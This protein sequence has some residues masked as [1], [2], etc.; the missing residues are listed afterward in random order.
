MTTALDRAEPRNM[1]AADR[2]ASGAASAR[3]KAI[4]LMLGAI[5]SFSFLDA[6]AKVMTG[7]LDTLQIVWARYLTHLLFALVL[8]NPF[9]S[10]G[11]FKSR[12]WTLEIV[13]AVLLLG[14][15]ACNFVALR[16]LQLDETTSIIFATP[17]LVAVLAG[18]LLGEWIGPRR[19]AAI[20]VGFIGV[21]IVLKPGFGG[22]HWAAFFSVLSMICYAFYSITTRKLAGVDSAGTMLVISALVALVALTPVVPF[23]WRTPDGLLSWVLLGLTG[24]FGGFG[25]WLL[26]LAHRLAPASILMPFTYSQIVWMVLLGYLVF[27]DVPTGS[28][29]LGAGVVIASGL[30]LLHRERIRAQRL[31]RA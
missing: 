11:L 7:Q 24:V 8:F 26:I 29:L 4:G 12:N 22:L 16:Y 23:V 13:R 6:S 21:L 27:N 14:S 25:H 19:W 30:Y 17:L 9:T 28:T 2:A 15:T 3:L 31:K 5:L 18:P 1:L 20:A 10:P